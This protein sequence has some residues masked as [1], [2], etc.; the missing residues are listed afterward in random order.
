M[1]GE[2]GITSASPIFNFPSSHRTCQDMRGSFIEFSFSKDINVKLSVSVFACTPNLDSSEIFIRYTVPILIANC[3][4]EKRIKHLNYRRASGDG[5]SEMS[6]DFGNTSQAPGKGVYTLSRKRLP[7]LNDRKK[8][9]WRISFF[10][11]PRLD[12]LVVWK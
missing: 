7:P 10:P 2:V 8:S 3:R 9:V 12:R 5:K 4:I 6:A 1:R 11:D